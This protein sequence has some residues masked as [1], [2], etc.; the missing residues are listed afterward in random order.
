MPPSLLILLRLL[1]SALG[2]GAV[3]QPITEPACI[4]AAPHLYFET[5]ADE[6]LPDFSEQ[7][8]PFILLSRRRGAFLRLTSAC[9]LVQLIQQQRSE[10]G[11]DLKIQTPASISRDVWTLVQMKTRFPFPRV[12]APPASTCP[13][14]IQQD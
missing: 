3:R 14:W 12:L 7:R 1:I 13:F 2:S 11:A 4:K 6:V 5:N 10:G 9:P 8:K